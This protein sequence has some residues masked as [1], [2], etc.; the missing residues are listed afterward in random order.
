MEF[1]HED[2]DEVG[3]NH[4]KECFPLSNDL[5]KNKEIQY[6]TSPEEAFNK[7]LP[8]INKHSNIIGSLNKFSY[9]CK[10]Y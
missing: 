7:H 8:A 5:M 3:N 1:E 9:S 6:P 4:Y 10:M 2:N